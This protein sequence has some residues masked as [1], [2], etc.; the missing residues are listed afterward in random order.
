MPS[1]ASGPRREPLALSDDEVKE[2]H[3]ECALPDPGPGI[4][5]PI[6]NIPRG[7]VAIPREGGHTDDFGYDVILHFHGFGPVRKAV[8]KTARGVVFAG[9]DLGDGSGP[10]AEA[11]S[12]PAA[13]PAIRESIEAALRRH[14]GDE[15]AHV[16]HLAL[17]AWSA[18]YGAVNA[19]VRKGDAG[20]DAVILLDG[21]HASFRPNVTR[22]DLTSSIEAVGVAPLIAYAQRAADGEKL[23]YFSHSA[24]ATTGY[25]STTLMANLLLERLG[26]S[27]RAAEP[28]DDP[29]ALRAFVDERGF[30]LRSFGGSDKRAHCDH[31]R[32]I[33]EAI[34]DYLEP[35]WET[36]AARLPAKTAGP[37]SI[38]NHSARRACR[39]ASD[40]ARASC[41][42]CTRAPRKC[43]RSAP[44]RRRGGRCRRSRFR[45]RNC[46]GRRLSRRG[47]RR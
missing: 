28:S 37:L 39:S 4:Y 31:T 2:G 9:L 46:G 5:A 42:S 44:G 35:A 18:G 26:L 3:W 11:L 33:A 24:I 15:R 19:I 29:L 38:V 1:L 23:F 8:A 12:E 21:L 34:R 20:V 27:R 32:A 41:S 25:A 47:P 14:S 40:R 7:H 30:H 22:F 43:G 36:P 16:R 17:S 10:Y 6:V 45:A 13:Y